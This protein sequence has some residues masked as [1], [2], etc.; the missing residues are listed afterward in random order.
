MRTGD[1]YYIDLF[2]DYLAMRLSLAELVNTISVDYPKIDLEN[3]LKRYEQAVDFLQL[4]ATHEHIQH[5]IM[6]E[7]EPHCSL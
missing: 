7:A 5:L 4:R 3:E 1:L 6:T 2:D